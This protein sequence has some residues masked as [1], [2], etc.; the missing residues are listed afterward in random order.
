MDLQ[1]ILFHGDISQLTSFYSVMS[2][3]GGNMGSIRRCLS[4]LCCTSKFT[5][6]SLF[7]TKLCQQVLQTHKSQSSSY[8][9]IMWICRTMFMLRFESAAN[10]DLYMACHVALLATLP[11]F[12]MINVSFSGH[13]IFRK[14]ISSNV[15]ES[16]ILNFYARHLQA[17]VDQENIQDFLCV[18]HIITNLHKLVS[19]VDGKMVFLDGKGTKCSECSKLVNIL[20]TL[21]PKIGKDVFFHHMM[22]T[23]L[24][25]LM[26]SSNDHAFEIALEFLFNVFIEVLETPEKNQLAN[27]LH[28][29]IIRAS[30]FRTWTQNSLVHNVIKNT[31]FNRSMA[32][33]LHNKTENSEIHYNILCVLTKT[34]QLERNMDRD[35][36]EMLIQCMLTN[37]LEKNHEYGRN[38]YVKIVMQL[39]SG[40]FY[41]LSNNLIGNLISI[42]TDEKQ[43]F[44]DP[45]ILCVINNTIKNGQGMLPAI[46]FASVLNYIVRRLKDDNFDVEYSNSALLALRNV[47]GHVPTTQLTSIMHLAF[48]FSSRIENEFNDNEEVIQILHIVRY[49]VLHLNHLSQLTTEILNDSH[50]IGSLCVRMNRLLQEKF[51]KKTT[52]NRK[53][54]TSFLRTLDTLVSAGICEDKNKIQIAKYSSIL[55]KSYK[56]N[57]S[58]LHVIL[59]ILCK[60]LNILPNMLT[61]QGD[62]MTEILGDFGNIGCSKFSSFFVHDKKLR[63]ACL[64][65]VYVITKNNNNKCCCC[66]WI[67][68]SKAQK[69]RQEI[70][71]NILKYCARVIIFMFNN[72]S[73]DHED[74]LQCIY[75]SLYMIKSAVGEKNEI[76]TCSV[77]DFTLALSCLSQIET[78]FRKRA[79]RLI[80]APIF[81][82]VVDLI[83]QI[84]N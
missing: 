39:I 13:D 58:M 82:K 66:G 62:V 14:S 36:Q 49:V 44:G 27:F 51:E 40:R 1:N 20:V 17:C 19:I 84:N 69:K 79:P 25:G 26:S 54:D 78:S 55:I 83:N 37:L 23:L 57:K 68:T 48:Y 24:E 71:A 74:E 10:A 46:F 45:T 33:L 7:L 67:G 3:D 52:C 12:S 76:K 73:S 60:N 29:S 28:C 38:L 21:I 80:N 70:C 41:L 2:E 22:F 42:F 47:M 6:K 61:E 75:Y 15:R 65:V 32:Y 59:R 5:R 18:G 64:N 53:L 34:I 31:G 63:R 77:P 35:T 56:H 4:N 43:E 72:P 9:K 16:G 30:D 50:F 81:T 11:T 8:N